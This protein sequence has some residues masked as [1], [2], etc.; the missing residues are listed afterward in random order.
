VNDYLHQ[1]NSAQSSWNFHPQSTTAANP[2]GSRDGGG[3][4][5]STA[6]TEAPRAIAIP[7]SNNYE[8]TPDP[9]SILQ[10]LQQHQNVRAPQGNYLES[11]LALQ[12]QIQRTGQLSMQP[13]SQLNNFGSINILLQFQ[14]Q[15]QQQGMARLSA[16][17]N[18]Y[19]QQL[20]DNQAVDDYSQPST[21]WQQQEQHPDDKK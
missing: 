10:A 15:L 4:M 13:Q 11:L 19:Q 12:Q 9:L 2:S 20:Q 14:Q 6:D 16:D 21:G 1:I 3:S 17:T 7:P 18:F 5:G 8:S